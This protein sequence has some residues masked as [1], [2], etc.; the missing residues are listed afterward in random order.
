LGGGLCRQGKAG[1][2]ELVVQYESLEPTHPRRTGGAGALVR[3]SLVDDARKGPCRRGGGVVHG[4]VRPRRRAAEA[5]R[6]ARTGAAAAE[7]RAAAHAANRQKPGDKGA[8][9]FTTFAR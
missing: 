9:D 7:D 8:Q 3:A 6:V 4:T 1:V 2:Q 5:A